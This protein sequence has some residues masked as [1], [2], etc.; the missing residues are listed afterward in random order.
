[1]NKSTEE[2]EKKIGY[3]FKNKKFL[4]TAL[5]HSSYFNEHRQ[6]EIISNERLEFLGDSVLSL[7]T[8]DYLYNRFNSNEGEL[9]KLKAIIVCEKTLSVFAKNLSFGDFLLMGKGEDNTECRQRPSTLADA[10]EAVLG[11]IYCDSGF[12]KAKQYLLP[13]IEKATDE[14]D[15]LQDYKTALQEIIQKN[16]GERLS[17]RIVSDSGV[18]HLKTFV[19]EVLLNSNCVGTGEGKS[20]KAAEQQAAFEALKLLGIIKNT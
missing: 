9:T 18:E 19:C 6:S 2:F 16:K 8:A 3:T 11:A 5:T 15:N 13:F 1:M 14:N 10:F 4:K 12:E 20:K 7:V 17:Y